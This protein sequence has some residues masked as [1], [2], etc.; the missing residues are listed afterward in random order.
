MIISD[1]LQIV[2]ADDSTPSSASV[3]D[4][5]FTTTMYIGAVVSVVGA[6]IAMAGIVFDRNY[7]HGSDRLVTVGGLALDR[8][9]DES[10][11]A[12][13]REAARRKLDD[14]LNTSDLDK[15]ASGAVSASVTQALELAGIDA[16]PALT[17][18]ADDEDR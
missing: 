13:E 11:D 5:I 9:L 2:L 17:R 6:M 15:N 7:D 18:G 12:P 10:V 16:Q 3:F 8:I 14:I 4:S 1:T